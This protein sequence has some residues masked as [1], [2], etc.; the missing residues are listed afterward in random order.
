MRS[1]WTGAIGFGL[2]TIPVK[3]YSATESS[4]LDFDM[5]DK[6]DHARIHFKR[7]N[8]H[9]GKE[10]AWGNIVKGYD[11]NGKYVVLTDDDFAAA[12]P[13]KTKRIEL[14]QFVKESE[15]DS[16]YYDTA[17]YLEPDKSGGKPYMLLMEAL[18]KTGMAGVG[19]F[20]LRNKE[21]LAV[22]KVHENILMVNKIRFH[23]EIRSTKDITLP[24]KNTIKPGELKMALA[25]I[26]Q[27]SEKFDISAYKDTYSDE[28]MKLI[29]AKAKGAKPKATV[30]R[31]VHK[32]TTDLM[33]QLKASLGKR[34]KAS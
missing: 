13:E 12:S 15:I 30:L 6:K 28:L 27:M 5:L 19:S 22:V 26:E 32:Q 7:V 25:L 3:L 4:T 16:I 24:A 14:F 11:L 29:K 34:K 2:V 31:V 17:Y 18:K 1:I 8:E 33:E 10:V 9:T 20:V 21:N 23:S